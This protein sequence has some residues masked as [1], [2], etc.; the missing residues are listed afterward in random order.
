[1]KLVVGA[2]YR[3]RHTHALPG[4]TA[5]SELLLAAIVPEARGLTA[6]LSAIVNGTRREARLLVAE[7][8]KV[9]YE[10][11]PPLE[12]AVAGHCGLPSWEAVLAALAA[13]HRFTL[14]LPVNGDPS[15]DA[16]TRWHE[17]LGQH[18]LATVPQGDGRVALA[19]VGSFSTAEL[20]AAQAA[21]RVFAARA[22]R[23]TP[24]WVRDGKL[25]PT[26]FTQAR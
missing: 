6:V 3:L 17:L 26:Y 22:A 14:P 2:R 21:V 8:E 9:L 16:F 15:V 19:K 18:G 20:D 13:G 7:A 24:P 1:M 23:E 10:P 12:V 11:P 4:I 25:D 5:G